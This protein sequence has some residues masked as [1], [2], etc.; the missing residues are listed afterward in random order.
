MPLVLFPFSRFA[1]TRQIRDVPLAQERS[2][3]VLGTHSL[4][5]NSQQ[6]A[7]HLQNA[8]LPNLILYSA[9]RRNSIKSTLCHW[10]YA[11]R[12]NLR[13]M[14]HHRSASSRL[15]AKLNRTVDSLPSFRYSEIY[16]ALCT[17]PDQYQLPRS[18]RRYSILK[19]LSIRLV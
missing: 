17:T 3:V 11:F 15:E 14:R 13:F 16:R 12:L 18:R 1:P 6:F 4:L 2:C 8:S 10:N 19:V 5:S 7:L 9:S